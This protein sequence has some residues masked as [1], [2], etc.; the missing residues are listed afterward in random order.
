MT[1]EFSDIQIKN[2]GHL[3]SI[4]NKL[5]TYRKS[6]FRDAGKC[7]GEPRVFKVSLSRFYHRLM[8]KASK[9]SERDQETKQNSERDINICEK[10]INAYN[11]K[12][13]NIKEEN[14]PAINRDIDSL[15]EEIRD[16]KENPSKYSDKARDSFKYYSYIV[17]LGGLF[18][19]LIIFY[20]SVIYSAFFRSITNAKETIYNSVFYTNVYHEASRSFEMLLMVI[21]G[22]F[23]FVALGM[24]LHSMFKNWINPGLKHK[25]G[26]IA[27]LIIT[28]LFDS[29]LAF[30]IAKKLHDAAAINSFDRLPD[31]KIADAAADPN[32]W[33][34]IF[35]GFI[36]YLI[37]SGVLMLFDTERN[38][39]LII[40]RLIK[41]KEEKLSEQYAKDSSAKNEISDYENKIHQ[42]KLEI[43]GI[44]SPGGRIYYSPHELKRIVSDYTL[45]WMQYLCLGKF[46]EDAVKIVESTLEQFYVEKGLEGKDRD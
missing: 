46:N 44:N 36:V 39:G 31:F 12:I 4:K 14:I 1:T 24:I 32:F 33:L 37:F 11:E 16:I 26:L 42:L 21:L 28:F 15:K 20:S 6:G 38:T 3:T 29:L 25:V 35:F 22:P 23:V 2:N 13:N 45:G 7:D 41:S 10:Q 18:L 40:E 43:A 19:F 34:V 30:H 17:L 8:E 5:V 27:V 9:N